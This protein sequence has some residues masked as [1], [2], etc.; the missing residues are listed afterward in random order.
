MNGSKPAMQ[1]SLFE[2]GGPRWYALSE[3]MQPQLVEVLS[4]V[5][6]D[7]LQHR[8]NVSHIAET[9]TEDDHES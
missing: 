1:R 6:L 7:A 2:S 5:L 4:Q 9:T 8:G 3:E